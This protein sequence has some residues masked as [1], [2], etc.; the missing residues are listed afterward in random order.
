M[1]ALVFGGHFRLRKALINPHKPSS[2]TKHLPAKDKTPLRAKVT[3][4][5]KKRRLLQKEILPG[6]HQGFILRCFVAITCQ[7][8]HSMGHHPA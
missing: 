5:L 2:T 7:V 1:M 4:R 8:Q 3:L 6:T